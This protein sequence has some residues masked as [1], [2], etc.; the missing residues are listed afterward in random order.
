MVKSLAQSHK[1]HDWDS[2]PHSAERDHQSLSSVL[3]SV[4]GFATSGTRW[5]RSL[6]NNREVSQACRYRYDNCIRLRVGFCF[7]NYNRYRAL[8]FIMSVFP[9]K[10]DLK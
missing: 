10:H 6:A 7:A 3:L 5:F 9:D 2:N 8:A 1:C 4:G